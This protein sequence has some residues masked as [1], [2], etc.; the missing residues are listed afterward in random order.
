MLQKFKKISTLI[1]LLVFLLT[2]TTVHANPDER[3]IYHHTDHLSGT[4]IDTDENGEIMQSSSYFPFGEVLTEEHA[5]DYKNNYKFTGK[6]LDES[7]L[8]Y[9]GARYYNPVIGRFVSQDTWAGDLRNPQSLNKYSY[10]FNNP[11]KYIDPTGNNPCAILPTVCGGIAAKALEGTL[12]VGSY[13][14]GQKIK[15]H[16]LENLPPGE[17]SFPTTSPSEP[18]TQDG[19]TASQEP[20]VEIGNVL[21][22]PL[23][24]P[25]VDFGGGVCGVNMSCIQ[26]G[27]D[28]NPKSTL[29]RDKSGNYLSDP[30]ATGPHTTLGVRKGR[31]ES[32]T[33]GATFDENGNFVGRTDVTNHGRSDHKNPHFHES[34]GPNKTK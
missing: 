25:E 20:T 22:D 8:Y 17:K 30:E 1:T 33:Q 3:I 11:L 26:A 12:Y 16:V 2:Q 10:V 34:D 21:T 31:S 4:S 23:Y 14:I 32:Y 6:E 29:P 9:Y 24:N 7:G 15:D 13:L 18:V 19:N 27:K 5:P 28:N